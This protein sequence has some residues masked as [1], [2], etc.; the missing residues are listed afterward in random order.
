MRTDLARRGLSRGGERSHLAV[1]GD[2]L[3]ER[4]HGQRGLLELLGCRG[5]RVNRRLET[6]GPLAGHRVPVD[7]REGLRP[8]LDWRLK[9]KVEEWK[10]LAIGPA[11]D[12]VVRGDWTNAGENDGAQVSTRVT[13][14][15]IERDPVVHRRRDPPCAASPAR[16]RIGNFRHQFPRVMMPKPTVR[17][18]KRARVFHGDLPWGPR[19]SFPEAWGSQHRRRRAP[20]FA[21]GLVNAAGARLPCAGQSS[22]FLEFRPRLA[23]GASGLLEAMIF[24]GSPHCRTRAQGHREDERDA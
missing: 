6:R 14:D 13:M 24:L 23:L 20:W 18:T 4:G 19:R 16:R 15:R 1:E 22:L 5:R 8:P 17:K 10:M 12:A 3:G 9:G 7:V 2:E 11:K 21:R